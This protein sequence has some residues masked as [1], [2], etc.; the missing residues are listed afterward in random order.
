[1]DINHVDEV[2]HDDE[3][4]E[5]GLL[6]KDILHPRIG[7]LRKVYGIISVQLLITGLWL[8]AVLEIETLKIFMS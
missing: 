6:G 1:M 3:E 8:W 5:D 4:C 7:F 2:H